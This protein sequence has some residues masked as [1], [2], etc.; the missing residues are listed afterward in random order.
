MN[1]IHLQICCHAKILIGIKKVSKSESESEKICRGN[2]FHFNF[3][4]NGTGKYFFRVSAHC[5][6]K[7]CAVRP[8]FADV[9]GELGAADPRSCLK[10]HES[11][12]EIYPVQNWSVEMP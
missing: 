11:Q 10:G 9:A 7:A 1:E 5:V 6:T 3:R 8:V 2:Y 12:I 4:V